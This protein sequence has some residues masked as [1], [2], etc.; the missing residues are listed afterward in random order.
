MSAK[1]QPVLTTQLLVSL[2]RESAMQDFVAKSSHEPIIS[3]SVGLDYR[4]VLALWL[5]I[6]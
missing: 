1:P 6:G 2:Q 3:S 5:W 4:L